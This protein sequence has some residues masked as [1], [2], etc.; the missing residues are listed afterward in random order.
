MITFK[1]FLYEAGSERTKTLTSEEAI[2]LIK[3]HCMGYIKSKNSKIY[4]GTFNSSSTFL[5]DSNLGKERK[6]ANTSNYY[7]LYLDNAP[8][9]KG[10]PKRS[11]SFICST[12]KSNAQGFGSLYLVLPYDDANIGIVPTAD[13]WHAFEGEADLGSLMTQVNYALQMGKHDIT[14]YEELVKVL[15]QINV[16]F[17]N[18]QIKKLK[19]EDDSHSS[20]YLIDEC[21]EIL[22]KFELHNVNNFLDYFKAVLT[23]TN[24]VRG[25]GNNIKNKTLDNEIY[26]QGKAIFILVDEESD[27]DN[28]DLDL[29]NYLQ[30]LGYKGV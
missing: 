12:D 21:K 27:Q 10:Y 29:V 24:F 13:L 28:V 3:Q 8:E 4:R 26:I 14:T 11:R 16:D 19:G 18:S 25:N 2:N 7:T 23:P 6:S 5:G 9:W 22:E 30:T 1:Q 17:L 20:S 15:P